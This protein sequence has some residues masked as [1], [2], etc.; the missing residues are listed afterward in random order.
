MGSSPPSV[1]ST[2]LGAPMPSI[3]RAL[4]GRESPSRLAQ[5]TTVHASKP[6]VKPMPRLS[7]SDELEEPSEDRAPK[8]N[9]IEAAAQ[10]VK[11]E[12]KPA[13]APKARTPS[14][15]IAAAG[16]N[17]SPD[18]PVAPR[19]NGSKAKPKPG[20]PF[21]QP[22]STTKVKGAKPVINPFDEI[23]RGSKSAPASSADLGARTGSSSGGPS[24]QTEQPTEQPTGQPTGQPTEQPTAVAQAPS[25]TTTP[26]PRKRLPSDL[27]D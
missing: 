13:A 25:A 19:R 22:P 6:P 9:P 17:P 3:S 2:P 27:F 4:G 21:A 18:P 15:E 24:E 16:T 14:P 7:V 1:Y 5:S 26:E 10:A 23:K 20:N 8:P 11:A 12:T